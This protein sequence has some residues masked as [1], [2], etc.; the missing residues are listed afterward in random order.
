MEKVHTEVSEKMTALSA[1]YMVIVGEFSVEQ[2][3]T[4]ELMMLSEEKEDRN[5]KNLMREYMRELTTIFF[6]LTDGALYLQ[7]KTYSDPF[8][9]FYVKSFHNLAEFGFAEIFR[10]K[11]YA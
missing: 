3:G 9:K 8:T 6:E 7:W 2:V 5:W 4:K 10:Q 1:H 11:D